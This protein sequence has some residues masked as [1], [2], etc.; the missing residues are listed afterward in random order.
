MNFDV[1][2]SYKSQDIAVAKAIAHIMESDDIKCWYAPRNLDMQTF[3]MN[4]DDTIVEAIKICKIV[5]VLLS[6]EA[7]ESEWVKIEVSCAQKNNKHI[8]P[9]VIREISVDNGLMNRLNQKHWVDAYPYPDKKFDLLLNN[10][11][12]ALNNIL[13]TDKNIKEVRKFE[14]V[15]PNKQ[16]YDLDFEEGEALYEAKEIVDATSAFLISAEKGNRKSKERLCTIFLENEDV[17]Q[18]IPE[19]IWETIDKLAKEGHCYANFLMHTKYYKQTDSGLISFEYLKKALKDGPMPEAFLRLGI[20]YGWGMGVKTNHTL[21][22]HYYKKAA[23]LGIADAYSFLGAEYQYGNDKIRKDIKTAI[24]YYEKGAE[25]KNKRS[26]EKLSWLYAFDPNY[27]DLDK[28]K[29]IAQKAIDYGF[30][31]GYVWMGDIYYYNGNDFNDIEESKEAQEWY[32]KGASKDV[33]SAYS[34]LSQLYWN[35]GDHAKAFQWARRG[36]ISRDSHSYLSLGW[37][38]EHEKEQ[39]TDAWKYYKQQYE[40]FGTGANNLARIYLEKKYRPNEEEGYQLKDLIAS[41]DVGARN[42]NEECIDYLI[43][44]YGSPQVFDLNNIEPDLHKVREYE[45]IG[46]QLGICKYIYKF[47]LRCLDKDDEKNYN[48]YKGL[49]LLEESASKEHIESVGKLLEIYKPRYGRKINSFEVVEE[50]DDSDVAQ[51]HKWCEFAIVNDIE[52][53]D[54]KQLSDHIANSETYTK[55]HS[56]FVHKRLKA[57]ISISEKAKLYKV[58]VTNSE[59]ERKHNKERY[60]E[61]E[62]TIKEEIEQNNN[63]G[64]ANGIV[65]QLYPDF[66]YKALENGSIEIDDANSKIY[67]LKRLCGKELEIDVQTRLHKALY[68]VIKEDIS[69]REVI[70]Q[71]INVFGT[72]YWIKQ[73]TSE[74]Y[75]I[76]KSY[77]SVCKYL[78]IEPI[79]FSFHPEMIYPAI[80][81]ETALKMRE[82]AIDTLLQLIR[83]GQKPFN[84]ISI[85]DS[86]EKILTLAEEEENPVLQIYL[87]CFIELMIETE[88]VLRENH[89]LMEAFNN[90]GYS[91]IVDVLD[92]Y[93]KAVEEAGIKHNLPEFTEDHVKY[94]C[95]YEPDNEKSFDELLDEFIGQGSTTYTI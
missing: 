16:E 37:Y 23:E 80:T 53:T 6:D 63:P 59:E 93:K 7:L 55:E 58:A 56:D 38:Y 26:L 39:L 71:N 47:A 36:V 54:R 2:I 82:W 20:H 12:L 57:C 5:I 3:G 1:F 49:K 77:E 40:L 62:K 14:I 33:K 83:I 34:S 72:D 41:L 18:L 79:P 87:I 29:Y 25:L 91:K 32:K 44:I 64:F 95:L 61:L 94:I 89:V 65:E 17:D 27:K 76:F 75:N 43:D 46:A 13:A 11:K 19:N 42:A 92:N 30:D 73:I 81:S 10:V 88:Y 60:L 70:E 8:I 22:L 4:Y 78:E 21:A 31:E 90:K 52:I 15:S 68:G 69:Y 28:A 35:L 9:F 74:E 48:T 86:D 85:T 67:R 66:D 84:T 51:Y 24:E 50:V 45:K